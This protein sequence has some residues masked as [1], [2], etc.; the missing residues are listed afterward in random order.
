MPLAMAT[1]GCYEFSTE[2]VCGLSSNGQTMLILTPW[3]SLV[4][5]V[6]ASLVGAF[7]SSKHKRTPLIG[8]AVGALA[9]FAVIPLAS[10]IADWL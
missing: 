5:G 8:L 3:V 2:W 9:Y 7:N 1:D 4:A 10:I 6:A